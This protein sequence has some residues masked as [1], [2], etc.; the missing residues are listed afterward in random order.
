MAEG[1]FPD[2]PWD[3]APFELPGDSP[4]LGDKLEGE[5]SAK[6]GHSQGG[7]AFPS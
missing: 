7:D 2:H 1:P 3:L 5:D 4:G 6:Q